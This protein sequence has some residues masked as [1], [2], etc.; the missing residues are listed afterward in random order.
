MQLCLT[1]SQPLDSHSASVWL[2]GMWNEKYSKV[3]TSRERLVTSGPRRAFKYLTAKRE[4]DRD[5]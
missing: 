4:C 3:I 2:S 1:A 5:W